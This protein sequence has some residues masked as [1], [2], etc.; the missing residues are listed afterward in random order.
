MACGSDF[1]F[2]LFGCGFKY[3]VVYLV[4][5]FLYFCIFSYFCIF[6]LCILVVLQLYLFHTFNLC[7]HMICA[8]TV[9]SCSLIWLVF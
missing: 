7:F 6:V 2:Q 4:M 3:L 8:C 9:V 1:D 5:L